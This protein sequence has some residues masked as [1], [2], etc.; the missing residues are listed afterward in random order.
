[1]KNNQSSP[2]SKLIGDIF[3]RSGMSEVIIVIIIAIILSMLIWYT[4]E[5]LSYNLIAEVFGAVLTIIVIEYLL[6]RAEQKEWKQVRDT[7]DFRIKNKLDHIRINMMYAFHWVAGA[8]QA[9]NKLE[10]ERH[11]LEARYQKLQEISNKSDSDILR[12]VL[13]E[14][15]DGKFGETWIHFAEDIKWY[16]DMK[17]SHHLPPDIILELFKLHENLKRLH[18]SINI[19]NK[20]Q[21]NATHPIYIAMGNEGITFAIREIAKSLVALKNLGYELPPGQKDPEVH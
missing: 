11:Y 15:L 16:L 21:G 1:M 7:I 2:L 18:S 10:L 17:Y 6:L 20:W 14:L 5:D 3:M 13:P 12:E 8:I 9:D 19:R 4:N